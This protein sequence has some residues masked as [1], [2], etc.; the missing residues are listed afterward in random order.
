MLRVGIGQVWKNLPIYCFLIK[1]TSFPPLLKNPPEIN[2]MKNPAAR[3]APCLACQHQP[4]TEGHYRSQA[5]T[6][7]I[8]I[9]AQFRNLTGAGVK[10]SFVHHLLLL[11]D[12]VSC[13]IFSFSS[14]TSWRRA[15]RTGRRTPGACS[16]SPSP[17]SA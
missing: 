14:L 17:A 10:C 5:L 15:A 1:L 12:I 11:Q 13:I 4:C 7:P 16:G 3:T 9:T 8:S 6:A 2:P